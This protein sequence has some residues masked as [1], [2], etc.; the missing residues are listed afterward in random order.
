MTDI[1]DNYA[2][3]E[4]FEVKAGWRITD[5]GSADW[6]LRRLG[7]LRREVDELQEMKD[8]AMARLEVKYAKL[9]S[10]AESGCAYFAT[11]LEVW[12]EENRSRLIPGKAKT[13]KL[14]HGSVGWRS[15]PARLEVTDS[16][17]LLV[18]AVSQPNPGLVRVKKTPAIDAI[19]KLHKETG[20]IPPGTSLIDAAELFVVKTDTG[21]IDGE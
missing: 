9:R 2:D 20:E 17:A 13:R 3:A 15:A 4:D 12:A 18:W 10:Q 19:Q 14:L 8:A 7:E 21:G 6:A 1:P 16:D 5:L 11:Q